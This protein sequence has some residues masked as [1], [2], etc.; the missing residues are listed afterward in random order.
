MTNQEVSA[1]FRTR[2][3]RLAPTR[4]EVPQSLRTWELLLVCSVH[5]VKGTSSFFS[6]NST[7]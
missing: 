1:L 2:T 6:L 4:S 5:S 3:K 7:S